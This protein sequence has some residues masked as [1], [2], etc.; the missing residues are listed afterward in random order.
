MTLEFIK[1][2]R[3]QFCKVAKNMTPEERF[4]Y[5]SEGADAGNKKLEQARK[6][7]ESRSCQVFIRLTQDERAKLET[8]AQQ[9]KT[10][11]SSLIRG[12]ALQETNHFQTI[13]QHLQKIESKLNIKK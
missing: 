10:T 6:E 12:R 4:K 9:E 3:R 11:L 7:K 1:K 8:D 5:I 2:A 13:L